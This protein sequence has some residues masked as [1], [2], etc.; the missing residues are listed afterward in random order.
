MA[1]D[2]ARSQPMPAP[3]VDPARLMCAC[4]SRWST[5]A[6]SITVLLMQR[7][8]F[9]LPSAILPA[10]PRKVLKDRYETAPESD[11]PQQ[12]DLDLDQDELY[13]E[14]QFYKESE[15]IP[16]APKIQGANVGRSFD[17]DTSNAHEEATS[18]LLPPL[19]SRN[20]GT[21]EGKLKGL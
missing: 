1:D 9:S 8:F 15:A 18:T 4:I 7:S 12:T 19:L 2:A 21:L 10:V 14:D 3:L 5:H 20:D 16:P 13:D 6:V 17:F 11:E